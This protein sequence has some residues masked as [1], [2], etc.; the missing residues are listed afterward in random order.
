[1]ILKL[2]K[3]TN[4]QIYI[5]FLSLTIGFYGI[6][7]K[8]GFVTDFLGW[9]HQFDNYSFKTIINGE[10]YQI[11]S[12]Y[13]VTQLMLYLMTKLF[14]MSPIPWFILFSNLF[15]INAF[16]LYKLFEKI[17]KK[18]NLE[19]G[20]S[21]AF[22]GILLFMLSPYQAEVMVWRA[23]F[24]YLTSFTMM[25]SIVHLALKYVE[26]PNPK[27]AY[28]ACGI[29][30]C[31]IFTLEYF[32]FTPFVVLIILIFWH[33]NFA[34]SFDFRKT[35]LRFFAIPLSIIGFYFILQRF[36]NGKWLA[37]GRDNDKT[38]LS[39]ETFG[40][41]GKYVT[42]HIFF[43]RHLEH[44]TKER[45]FNFFDT[46]SVSWS[47]LLAVVLITAFCLIFRDKLSAKG[48]L[49][50]LNFS[51]FS[52]LIYPVLNL[53]FAWILLSENDRYC[54]MPS[55]FLCVG[56]ALALSYFPKPV[57]YAVTL[58]YLGFSSILLIKTNRIWWKSEKVMSKYMGDFSWENLDD[59]FILA[60][61]DNYSGIPMLRSDGVASN[62]KEGV[63]TERRHLIKTKIHDVMLYNMTTPWDGVNV[64]VDS[65][66]VI[67]VT[68]NQWGNWWFRKGIGAE[69]YETEDYIVKSN[70]DGGGRNY[71]LILKNS[72]PNRKFIFQ[73]GDTMKEVD[74][75]KIRVVQR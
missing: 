29:F 38:L 34:N 75:S 18:I 36:L 17:F 49:I 15:A 12:L 16:L 25:L 67:I 57:F 72:K 1:M 31:S 62:L 30:F 61:P 74:M 48:K 60:A 53:Y 35:A 43:A 52:I 20:K 28:V 50:F 69:D 39:P 9:M 33:L 5:V 54:Y 4:F 42:K 32:L 51:L 8:A 3:N 26:N 68:L 66:N 37:H 11:K 14:R 24:H 40:A 13:Q 56:F 44:S 64:R 59:V 27:Y 45:L 7:Y 23:S 6:T 10:N 58:L 46:P 63:E 71:K 41:Y 21:I 22:I 19:G 73:V 2:I 55:A 47:I 65:S 70:Y